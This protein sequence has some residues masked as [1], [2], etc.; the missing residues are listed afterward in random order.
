MNRSLQ[1][2]ITIHGKSIIMVAEARARALKG[3][4]LRLPIIHFTL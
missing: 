4:V 1:S 2:G 3:R